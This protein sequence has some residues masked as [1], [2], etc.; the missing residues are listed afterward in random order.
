[1]R[2]KT[3]EQIVSELTLASEELAKMLG[4]EFVGMALFGSWARSEARE[5]S[6]VDVLVVF[7]SLGGM[8]IRSS[9]YK[10]IA[11]YVK[12]PVTLVDIRLSELMEEGFELTPLLINIV[13]DAVIIYDR[14][15]VRSFIDRGRRLIEKARLVRYKTPDGKYGWRRKDMEPIEPVEL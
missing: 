6:D 9:V 12:R 15:G 5:D 11:R 8:R 4:D 7:K 14:G 3:L 2:H 10:V 1:M 13:A